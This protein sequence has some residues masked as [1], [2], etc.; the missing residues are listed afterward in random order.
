MV[1]LKVRTSHIPLGL[2][3]ED[4]DMEDDDGEEEEFEDDEEE[5]GDEE[6]ND[7]DSDEE[8]HEEEEEGEDGVTDEVAAGVEVDDEEEEEIDMLD[9]VESV[10]D[11]LLYFE[12]VNGD[13]R[14]NDGHSDRDSSNNLLF[15]DAVEGQAETLTFTREISAPSLLR[16]SQNVTVLPSMPIPVGHVVG[17]SYKETT[18][19]T[20][21]ISTSFNSH[22]TNEFSISN[23]L[24]ASW[25]ANEVE[26]LET[27]NRYIS[28]GYPSNVSSC[29]VGKHNRRGVINDAVRKSSGDSDDSDSDDDSSSCVSFLSMGSESF[30]SDRDFSKK[31]RSLSEE[32]VTTDRMSLSIS[33][34]E[35]EGDEDEDDDDKNL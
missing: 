20:T 11:H 27:S 8:E 14:S 28:S 5:E 23:S 34:I 26:N 35:E 31:H 17:T 30:S 22:T 13:D 10:D 15:S 24:G 1:I 33:N 18:T 21:T 2:H 32:F 4:F 3:T 25:V 19:T 29:R 12:E 6:D 9:E 16:E 7:D